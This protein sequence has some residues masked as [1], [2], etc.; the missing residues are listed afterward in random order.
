MLY[1]M[2]IKRTS[3][4][5]R[6]HCTRLNCKNTIGLPKYEHAERDVEQLALI[7][8]WTPYG[9]CDVHAESNARRRE[10]ARQLV[11]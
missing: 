1:T 11:Q 3:H 2:K 9:L 8:G 10:R 7:M 6:V 4:H 5:V